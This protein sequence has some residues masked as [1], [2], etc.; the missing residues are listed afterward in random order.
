MESFFDGMDKENS[1]TGGK[2]HIKKIEK[3]RKEG[4]SGGK[5]KR[6]FEGHGGSHTHVF[7][8]GRECPWPIA[9]VSMSLKRT[10]SYGNLPYNKFVL[11]K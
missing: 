1:K 8:I 7:S 10:H 5:K 9:L 3:K 6:D 2:G 11:V 4:K